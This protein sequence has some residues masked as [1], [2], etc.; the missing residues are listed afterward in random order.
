VEA[1]LTGEN[2]VHTAFC[3][4]GWLTKFARVLRA[5]IVIEANSNQFDVKFDPFRYVT[6]IRANLSAY[7]SGSCIK[8][9]RPNVGI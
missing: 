4:L 3:W 7:A 2:P 6:I 5:R 9:Q 8:L 1:C